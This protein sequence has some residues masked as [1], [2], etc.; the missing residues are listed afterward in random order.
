MCHIRSTALARYRPLF[1]SARSQLHTLPVDGCVLSV[2]AIGA[3]LLSTPRKR[4]LPQPTSPN[5]LLRVSE[6]LATNTPEVNYLDR[7]TIRVI[8]CR[9]N[10]ERLLCRVNIHYDTD[11]NMSLRAAGGPPA[12]GPG[13]C[14]RTT[15]PQSGIKSSL[16]IALIC[17]TRRQIPASAGTNHGPE[18]GDLILL[19]GLVG[20]G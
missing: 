12:P 16:S 20:Y 14:G 18:K 11:R 15:S 7:F 5:S 4:N 3:H 17:T 19:C 9:V 8:P 2:A 13:H 1:P 6:Q 10:T